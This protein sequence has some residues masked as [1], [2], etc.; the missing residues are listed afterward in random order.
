MHSAV[1]SRVLVCKALVQEKEGGELYK[2]AAAAGWLLGRFPWQR[3]WLCPSVPVL[4]L[5]TI[6]YILEKK[7]KKKKQKKKKKK[8]ASTLAISFYSEFGFHPSLNSRRQIWTVFSFL[9]GN[10]HLLKCDFNHLESK[11]FNQVFFFVFFNRPLNPN[12]YRNCWICCIFSSRRGINLAL[13][14]RK[15]TKGLWKDVLAET[16]L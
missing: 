6:E 9:N 13:S 5:R 1:G 4:M 2:T 12:S 15:P 8:H 14:A 16:S 10:V 11:F 7:K 3:V